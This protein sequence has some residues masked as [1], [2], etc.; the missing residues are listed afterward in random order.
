MPHTSTN[1]PQLGATIVELIIVVSVIGSLTGLLFG[2]FND[3]YV[4]SSQSLRA[5]VQASDTRG[6]LRT[7]E[8]DVVLASRFLSENT[9]N[10]LVNNI[11]SKPTGQKWAWTGN[12]SADPTKRVL[13]IEAFGSKPTTVSGVSGVRDIIVSGGGCTTPLTINYAY[14]V[15]NSNLYR[16]TIKSSGANTG[17]NGTIDQNRTCRVGFN[18]AACEGIDA[19]IISG[20]KSFTV[21]YYLSSKEPLPVAN[22]YTSSSALTNVMTVVLSITTS[23][24]QGSNELES[25]STMRITRLND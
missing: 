14:Y 24:G 5:L 6:A 18:N 25:T 20:V 1:S 8:R 3:L 7:I 9:I 15:H 21:D 12:P 22:Q 11:P 16:R 10:D 2:P 13:I 19:L 23:S 17:C 4:S